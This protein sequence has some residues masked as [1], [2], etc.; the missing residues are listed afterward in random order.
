[1]SLTPGSRIGPYEVN[2]QIGAGGMGEVYRALD[3]TLGRQVAIK[4][5][6]ATVAHD[7]ERLAR[8]E[9]EA[10]TLAALNHPNVAHV[11]GLEKAEGLRALVMELVEGPDLA[12]RIAQGPIPL[13]EALTIA[14]QVADALEAAHEQG[15][16]HRDLKPANIKLRDDGTVKVLD[17]GLAKAL[18]ASTS[19]STLSMSPTLTS[20]APTAFGMIIGTAAYMAPEQAKG[21]PVDKRA[22]IWAFGVVLYEMLTRRKLFDGETVSEV[23]AAVIMR[24]PD[25]S[26]LSSDVPA[27]VKQLIARCL[28]RDPK[29]RLRDIGEARLQLATPGSELRPASGAEVQAPLPTRARA[30]RW[31]IVLAATLAVALAATAFAWWRAATARPINRVTRYEVRPLEKSTLDLSSRPNLTLSPDGSTLVYVARVDGVSRLY[32]RGRGDL[33]SR[34]LPGTEEATNPVFSLDGSQIAFFADGVLKRSSLDGAV[35][36]VLRIGDST[37]APRRG[38]TWLTNDRLVYAPIA[39]GALFS[40]A[41]TGGT[42]M[43]LTTLDEKRGERT[44]RW[45]FA[46]PGGKTVLFTVGSLS[47]PDNYD[48]STIEAVDVAT[49]RRQ[50]VLQGASSARYVATGHLLIARAAALYAVPFDLDSLTTSGT[51]VQVLQGINGDSTTGAL[52]LAIAEDGTTAYAPGSSQAGSSRLMWVDRTGAAQA[53]PL[54]QGL[55]FDPRLS[56]DGTRVAVAW[57]TASSGSSDIW[58]S[59]LARNTFTRLSFSGSSATPTWSADGRTIYYSYIDPTGRKSTIMRTPADGGRDP[60][61]VVV[62]DNARVYVESIDRDEKWAIVDH[63]APGAVGDVMKVALTANAKPEPVVATQFDDLVG[64]LSPNGRWLAYSSAETG[65]FEVY[66]R[67]MSGTNARWQLSTMG[68]EEPHWSADGREIY[69]RNESRLMSVSVGTQ[70]VLAPKAPVLVF[71]G[72]HDFRSD[73]GLSF[74][75]DPKGD[76]FLMIRLSGENTTSSIVV[77]LDWFQELR[78]LV[79]AGSG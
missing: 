33:V 8:F 71:D 49:G 65:R 34:V 29:L 70:A 11:Y 32:V 2:V 1:M 79:P 40:V 45:P 77:V 52:H 36:E 72:V 67:D 3:T 73:T 57:Q 27:H 38:M 74:A 75:V 69:Y 54:P 53:L 20:P 41:A 78:R 16:V 30:S 42:P 19:S 60:E 10:K 46:L 47:S 63:T 12:Q 4:I 59:D 22:D 62:L 58:V 50:V 31:P 37:D 43:P 13:D 6:P 15:I 61:P 23:L 39:A 26:A 5:L 21:K 66:V 64:A 24:E 44:H 35:S 25:L 51:P 18:E 7:P 55:F 14:R 28:V 56:P 76:R 17:F 9:R 68:G 48:E